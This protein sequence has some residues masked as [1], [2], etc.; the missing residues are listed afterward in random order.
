MNPELRELLD[1]IIAKGK[2]QG[3]TQARIAE[4]AGIGAVT[5]SRAKRAEDIQFSTLQRLAKS[6]GL[7]LTLS[8]DIPLAAKIERGG[9]FK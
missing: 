6:V 3:K 8:P 9:L 5:L 4:D 1:E 7:R 2:R